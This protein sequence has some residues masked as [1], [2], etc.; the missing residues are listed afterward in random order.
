LL[1]GAVKSLLDSGLD[2]EKAYAGVQKI[3]SI[4]GVTDKDREISMKAESI[5]QRV[6][7]A[8]ESVSK[9]AEEVK[10]FRKGL[11]VPQAAWTQ[12]PAA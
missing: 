5:A 6:L 1:E 3:A 10:N 7:G 12:K 11:S 8:K 2:M 9:I 4:T